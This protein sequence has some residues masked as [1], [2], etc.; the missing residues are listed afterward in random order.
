MK[1]VTFILMMVGFTLIHTSCGDDFFDINDDPLAAT[2]P[3]ADLLFTGAIAKMAA[4][5]VIETGPGFLF[6][7]QH[8]A[9]SGAAGVFNNPQRFIIGTF[10]PR[11]T[12]NILYE[13]GIKN[14]KLA[15]DDADAKGFVNTSAQ[16]RIMQAHMFY[17][18]TV[19]FGDIPYSQ[20]VNPEF[21]FPAFDA[22]QDVLNGIVNDLDDALSRIDLTGGQAA[23]D[24]DLLYKG[25]M[26]K[27]QRYGNSVKLASLML[28]ASGNDAAAKGKISELITSNA[29]LIT[30]VADEANVPFFDSPENENNLWKLNDLYS[31]NR[32]IWFDAG[33]P[34]VD[35]MNATSDPRRPVYFEEG[36]DAEPGQFVGRVA[37]SFA[38]NDEISQIDLNVMEKDFPDRLMA[39]GEVLLLRAEAYARGY[40]GSA[41]MVKADADLKAGIQASVDFFK[42]RGVSVSDSAVSAFIG[43]FDLPSE[44]AEDARRIIHEQQYVNLFARGMEAWTQWRRVKVPELPLPQSAQLD[45]IIRRFPIAD[46]ELNSNPNAEAARKPLT[47]PMWF[48]EN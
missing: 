26:E 32:N 48:E 43:S 20:A 16:L 4:V 47:T 25:D 46:E 45:D 21:N 11:N 14:F 22:Q 34:L 2:E 42:A 39:A 36:S 8:W 44:S 37:G 40:V 12:W 27:W 29:P 23:T 24:G 13:G 10:G 3:D 17:M 18:L 33:K 35:L 19:H 15:I 5:R 7:S 30:S 41:D 6:F 38:D 1:R 9:S 31:S 28:L